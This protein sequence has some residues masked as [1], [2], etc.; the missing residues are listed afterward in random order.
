MGRTW[1]ISDPKGF[2][3][4][5]ME[6]ATKLGE[7]YAEFIHKA[8]Y[9]RVKRLTDKDFENAKK[10]VEFLEKKKMLSTIRERETIWLREKGHKKKN[11][12]RVKEDLNDPELEEEFLKLIEPREQI[13]D[14]VLKLHE[15]LNPI[16][17]EFEKP[18]KFESRKEKLAWYKQKVK[19]LKELELARNL[20][21][22]S[23]RWDEDE[24]GWLCNLGG[25][26]D[27]KLV[28]EPVELLDHL[29]EEHGISP[30]QATFDAK[31]WQVG[32]LWRSYFKALKRKYGLD[33]EQMRYCVEYAEDNDITLEEAC[34]D[35][36]EG[37]GRE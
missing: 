26:E 30:E 25:G 16:S 24:E 22:I 12:E 5:V 18:P 33:D 1:T 29:K 36:A 37:S 6:V 34:K 17:V 32:R 31:K 14:E 13:A 23:A 9:E 15:E 3:E 28:F 27:C 35:C 4:T 20:S 19:K 7:G 8:V 2:R 21:R 10:R 11:I